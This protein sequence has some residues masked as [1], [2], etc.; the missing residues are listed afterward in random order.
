MPKQKKFE[1]LHATFNIEPIIEKTEIEQKEV[2]VLPDQ[3]PSAFDADVQYVFSV[4]KATIVKTQEALDNALELANET[5]S[6]RA[7]EV[8]GQLSKQ[9]VESAEKIIDIHQKLKDM[10][11]DRNNNSN[12]NVTQNNAI[13]V[14]TTA[15][16]IKLVKAQINDK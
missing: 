16:A 11:E 4:I 13:F 2:E 5:D 12:G 9:T 1:E 8:V 7:Y 10:D 6:A 14:G 3:K 15:E